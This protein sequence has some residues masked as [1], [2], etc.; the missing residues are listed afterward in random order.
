M[1][2]AII[3]LNG[4]L[5]DCH[6]VKTYI[7]SDDFII[8]VDGG[9]GHALKLGLAPHLVIGD[10]DSLSASVKKK[11]N[12]Q[13]VEWLAFPR[14]K[15]KTDGQ[16]ALNEAL[17]RGY[18]KIIVCGLLGRRL[19]HMLSNLITCATRTDKGVSMTFIE[20]HQELYIVKNSS[21]T[22]A[23]K[24]GELFSLIPVVADCKGV[25]V[26][27]CKYP[28]KSA[29]LRLDETRGV[30]NVATQKKVTIAVKSGTLF[31]CR[32]HG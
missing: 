16:L 21:V 6:R 23:T 22:C 7:R 29:T 8:G 11:L 32:T 3:F 19:D 5:A 10:F 28:L 18:K 12:E 30:S 20:G 24:Q 2:Q 15:D 26:A 4:D 31:I 14:D 1:K 25:T 13:N 27:G 9:A 17:A